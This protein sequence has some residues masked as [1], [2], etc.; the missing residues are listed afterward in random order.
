MSVATSD[1]SGSNN[2]ERKK[3]DRTKRCNVVREIV[4]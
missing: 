2:D 3:D 4:E 1:S